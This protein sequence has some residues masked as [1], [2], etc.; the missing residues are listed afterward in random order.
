MGKVDFA[1]GE[2]QLRP[3]MRTPRPIAGQREKVQGSNVA[4][5]GYN[6]FSNWIS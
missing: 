5:D 1:L 3:A 6:S 2:V 4:D